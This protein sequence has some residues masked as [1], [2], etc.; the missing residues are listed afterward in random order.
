M[1]LSRFITEHMEDIL[2]EWD[3]FARTLG[4]V[5]TGMT[6]EALRD[7]GRQ[8]LQAAAEDI[9]QN[10]SPSQ[11]SEKSQGKAA[12]QPGSAAS[13]H[14]KVRQEVGFTMVQMVAEYRA[15]RATV[16]RLWLKTV[17]KVTS[18][19]T[20]DM[21]RF[22]EAMDQAVAES[23]ARFTEQTAQTRD[24]FLA[25]LGHDLRTPLA[26]ITMA[27][28]L[29][30][31]PSVGTPQTS[32]VGSRVK[33]SAAAMSAMVNDLLEYAR[34][35]LGDGMPVTRNPADVQEICRAAMDELAMAYPEC[36]FELDTSG[37]LTGAFDKAR[38]Q[39]ALTNL[40]KNAVQYR[41]K[42]SPVK[43]SA[44]EAHDA[45]VIQVQNR[46][47]VIPRDSLETI[48]N[49]LVQLPGDEH[50]EGRP[51]TSMGLGLFIAREVA[52]AHCGTIRAESNE[53]SGT[54]FTIRIPKFAVP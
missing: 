48:F 46:G 30:M 15:L 19:T 9:E 28:D 20:N 22:N 16:L 11:Q 34:S 49:P 39:Q 33:R 17:K 14:G 8:I 50:L 36:R 23:T 38:L 6:D 45:I 51:S 13:Q 18:A 41:A 43:I 37:D 10:E 7:H 12:D 47:P 3:A 4:P 26:A 5:A 21:I 35:Q 44:A 24:T 54:V 27:G 25:I 32:E 1:K 40:L 42:D 53:E 29:L 52:E 2:A 31:K